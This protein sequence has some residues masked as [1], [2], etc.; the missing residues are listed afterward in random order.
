MNADLQ[1]KVAE[2]ALATT[3]VALP[4]AWVAELDIILRIILTL[5]GI[6][7]GIYATLYYRKRWKKE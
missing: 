7:S 6:V 1:H 3:G 4:M 5:V 2:V